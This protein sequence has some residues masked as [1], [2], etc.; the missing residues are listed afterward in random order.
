MR[1]SHDRSPLCSFFLTSFLR[2]KRLVNR[3]STLSLSVE[4]RVLVVADLTD[5]REQAYEME[6]RGNFIG[7]TFYTY[8][9]SATTL[10]TSLSPSPI[11]MSGESTA[12]D[13]SRFSVAAC[14]GFDMMD[15][16]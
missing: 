12:S 2:S 13:S 9:V 1:P 7:M 3:T 5:L 14:V 8:C 4:A 10:V 11:T 6:C 15:G 16:V